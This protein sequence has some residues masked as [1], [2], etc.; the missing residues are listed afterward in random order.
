MA[1]FTRSTEARLEETEREGTAGKVDD[2]MAGWL[3]GW[4]LGD[5]E[6]MDDLV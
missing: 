5:E 3:A 4:L 6:G 2:G 1:L